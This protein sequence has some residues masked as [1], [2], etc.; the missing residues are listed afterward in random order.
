MC[1]SR[2][3]FT[4]GF[5][6]DA[7]IGITTDNASTFLLNFEETVGDVN[8]EANDHCDDVD[9]FVRRGR[10]RSVRKRPE[11]VCT[12]VTRSQRRRL[13]HDDP[14]NVYSK[15][16]NNDNGHGFN[17]NKDYGYD[18]NVNS[19]V[20]DDTNDNNAFGDDANDNS[21]FGDDANDNSGFCDDAN[22]NNGFGD[23]AND[24]SGFCDDANDNSGFCDD[25]NDNNGFCDD[26]NDNNGS[27]DDF[28]D[29]SGFC[30]DANDNN[31][32]GDG[33]YHSSGNYYGEECGINN[34]KSDQD[35]QEDVLNA[36]VDDNAISSVD[37][38]VKQD[39]I[40]L[41]CVKLENL[42]DSGQFALADQSQPDDTAPDDTAPDDTTPDDTAP[43]DT[44]PDVSGFDDGSSTWNQSSATNDTNTSGSQQ[45]RDCEIF[46]IGVLDFLCLDFVLVR[47]RN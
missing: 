24:N 29:N 15:S 9:K 10:S 23:D 26:A 3:Q 46:E 4:K 45:V 6:I 27:Y 31:D 11:I 14:Q 34:V 36:V 47:V 42:D 33:A 43:D 12:R 25:T 20:W 37:E 44:A 8:T 40:I 41:A 22:D 38:K 1:K 16:D 2:L 18:A 17:D 30:D 13:D 35:C 7:L 19:C 21:G 32:D 28:N 39:H 5:V